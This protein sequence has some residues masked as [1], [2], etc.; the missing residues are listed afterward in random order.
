LMVMLLSNEGIL[1][2]QD[3]PSLSVVW[4]FTIERNYNE[5]RN[6]NCYFRVNI[7]VITYISPQFQRICRLNANKME[8]WLIK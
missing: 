5:I 1:I 4:E 7:R 3:P 2:F 8:I 6:H